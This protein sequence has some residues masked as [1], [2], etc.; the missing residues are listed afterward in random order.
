MK[1]KVK[2]FDKTKG[3]GFISGDDGKEYFVH[4]SGLKEGVI[5]N[6]EDAVT[7]TAEE[8]E[9]GPKAVDVAKAEAAEE[10]TP[11][12]QPEESSEEESKEEAS[13]EETKEE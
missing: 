13:E 8:G 3:F 12:E 7:F 6:D 11:E 10:E 5:L 9:R 2:F 4:H 1:G